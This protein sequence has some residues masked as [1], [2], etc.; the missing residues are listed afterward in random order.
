ML[1]GELGDDRAGFDDPADQARVLPRIDLIETRAEDGDGAAAGVER[2]EVRGGVDA[3]A[4][5]LTITRPASARSWPSRRATAMPPGVARREPTTATAGS[6]STS[7]SPRTH[8]TM[9]GS[10]NLTEPGG[11]RPGRTTATT[12]MPE[13]RARSSA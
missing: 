4:S 2:A 1:R 8:S 5:P 12:V 3:A 6:D 7:V 13:G 9:G 11:D 10:A